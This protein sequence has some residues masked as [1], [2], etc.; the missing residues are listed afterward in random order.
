[1]PVKGRW[2][3]AG[4]LSTLQISS[5]DCFLTST[6]RDLGAGKVSGS[7]FGFCIIVDGF[8]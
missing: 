1:M 6:L 8:R 7:L 5:E 4:F 3:S 2:A